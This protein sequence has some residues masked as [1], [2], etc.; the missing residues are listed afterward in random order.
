[1]KRTIAVFAGLGILVAAFWAIYV[2]VT[3]PASLEAQPILWVL[4]QITLPIASASAHYHFA[5]KL[6]WAIVANAVTYAI[7]G[8]M[9]EG[10]RQQLR[11][12]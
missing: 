2:A 4:V 9:V 6:Y 8:A 12:A 11:H 10:V 3:F 1:M 5:V 7:V